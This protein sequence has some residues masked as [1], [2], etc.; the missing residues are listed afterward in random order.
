MLEIEAR[1]RGQAVSGEDV[2]HSDDDFSCGA[3][4]VPLSSPRASVVTSMKPQ[5]ARVFGKQGGGGGGRGEGASNDASPM[6]LAA[7]ARRQSL[8]SKLARYARDLK[9]RA[10]AQGGLCWL[11]LR[12]KFTHVSGG[13]PDEEPFHSDRTCSGLRLK[14]NSFGCDASST[15]L[16]RHFASSGLFDTPDVLDLQNSLLSQKHASHILLF[17][18]RLKKAARYAGAGLAVA[19]PFTARVSLGERSLEEALSRGGV[20]WKR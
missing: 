3:I 2:D 5:A 10:Q 14:K 13:R 19:P 17:R 1:R 15:A 12:A 18:Q 16:R 8:A 7:A 6:E 11:L 20:D 9:P 4:P